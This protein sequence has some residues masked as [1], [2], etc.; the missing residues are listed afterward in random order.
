MT[1]SAVKVNGLDEVAVV[2]ALKS[3]EKVDV[4]GQ[5]LRYPAAG[6]LAKKRNIDT[7]R[8][9]TGAAYRPCAGR[10]AGFDE[11]RRVAGDG[12]GRTGEGLK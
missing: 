2:L 11:Q 4:S 12:N 10:S 3:F 6:G 1:T 7:H 9:L 5:I 8:Q